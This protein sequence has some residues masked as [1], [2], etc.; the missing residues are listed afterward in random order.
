[1]VSW[2]YPP[3]VV[4]G[5]GRHVHHLATALAA[6]G[7]EV[8]VLSRRP[9]DTDPSTHPSTDEI[10]EG[11]RVVAAAQDPH[12][13]AFGSDM[14]AW[15]LAMGHAMMRAGLAVR[16]EL[17]E[18]WVPDLVHAHDWLVAHP[19]I[20]LAEFFDV[21]LVSTIHATEAGRH[22]GW[23]SGPISRQVHAIESWLVH[24]SDSLITCSASMSDE[25][26]ELF[27]P[28]LA[29]THVIR[30][31]IDAALWPFAPRQPRQG[32]PQLLYVGRLKV[33]GHP[34]GHRG[35]TAD[36][37]RPSRYHAHHRR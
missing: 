23:V 7:H 25:I 20:A 16:D 29:E 3:V 34:G 36:P 4:G 31:G 15:I 33:E 24:E 14:M 27:G 30:N 32:P 26:T 28:A 19:A 5:L 21:P 2:E 18:R 17:G 35:A 6:A 1:M 11:V 37:P 22:S 8:V 13:F 12:E 9:A 10:S